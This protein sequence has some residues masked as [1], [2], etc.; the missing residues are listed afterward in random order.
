MFY[1]AYV[2]PILDYGSSTWG[3]TSS[4]NIE[5]LSKLQKRAARIILKADFMTPSSNMFEQLNWL[6]IP[7]R[8][9]YNKAILVY[10][11]LNTSNLT[12]T[13]ISNLLKPISKTHSR[14]LRS[15][16]NGILSIRRSRSALFDRS[17]SHSAAK[18]WNTLPQ[19]M[20]TASSL[21]EFKSCLRDYLWYLL[22]ISYKLCS[23]VIS[24]YLQMLLALF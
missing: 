16:E 14:S 5:R 3:A 4:T 9:M 12:P 17:F 6:S 21:N 11:A 13:Y 19:N 7:K 15:S 20:R 24:T 8:F 18:L 22:F 23:I 2:L 1:Q 10:K